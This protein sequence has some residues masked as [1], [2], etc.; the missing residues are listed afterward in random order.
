MTL[1]WWYNCGN[2][3]KIQFNNLND[4]FFSLSLDNEPNG[5]EKMK[6]LVNELYKIS[7]HL[8]IQTNFQQKKIQL[9]VYLKHKLPEITTY[10]ELKHFKKKIKDCYD[11]IPINDETPKDFKNY[12]EWN[13]DDAITSEDDDYYNSDGDTD[14]DSDD[15]CNS[16]FDKNDDRYRAKF[17]KT[18]NNGILLNDTSV[19]MDVSGGVTL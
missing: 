6:F 18:W 5:S 4:M 19:V 13:S 2:L 8:W 9:V 16:E 7:P 17:Y 1:N 15:N 3:R 11:F 14:D 10:D 12:D